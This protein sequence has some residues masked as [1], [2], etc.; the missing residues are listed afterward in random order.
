MAVAGAKNDAVSIAAH[1]GDAKTLLAFDVLT[2]SA[3][4]GLA[5]FTIKVKPP[6]REAYYLINDLQFEHPDQ[7]ARDPSEAENS[8]MNAPIHKFRWLHVPGQD[9]QGLSPEFGDYTYTVTPRYFNE[10]NKMVA[11]EAGLSLDVIVRLA[12]NRDNRR[13][14]TISITYLNR[15]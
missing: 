10:T 6:T 4:K 15:R 3:K 7:H 8:T 9:H 11:F 14:L 12:P 5:G 1:R 13:A 2:D